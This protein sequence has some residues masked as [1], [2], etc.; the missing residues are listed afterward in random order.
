MYNF[1]PSILHNLL[2]LYMFIH[3]SKYIF[4]GGDTGGIKQPRFNFWVPIGNR[5]ASSSCLYTLSQV[6][7]NTR[8]LR[9][10]CL[11]KLVWIT[12]SKL[13]FLH[14]FPSFFNPFD[15][16]LPLCHQS[17]GWWSLADTSELAGCRCCVCCRRLRDNSDIETPPGSW[18][19]CLG[20]DSLQSCDVILINIRRR[21]FKTSPTKVF[22][23]TTNKEIKEGSPQQKDGEYAKVDSNPIT[24]G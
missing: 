14:F 2:C 10:L 11:F 16:I 9:N 19:F 15:W 3:Y 24:V 13:F 17:K 1:F 22:E 6:G 8:I 18:R 12:L 5:P 21:F 20:R 7:V 4:S 23:I